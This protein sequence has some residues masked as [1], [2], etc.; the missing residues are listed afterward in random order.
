MRSPAAALRLAVLAA[1]AATFPVAE[2]HHSFA[3]EFDADQPVELH[4]VITKMEWLNPH[5]WMHLDVQNTDG[6]TTAWMIEGGTPNTLFRRGFT[7]QAVPVGTEIT[8]I[9]YRA[10]NG[11]NRANGRDLILSDGRR[12]FMG[13]PGTGAPGDE[14]AASE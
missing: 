5:T 6:T 14:G 13:S 1:F 9:G 7:P 10:R 3:A 8:V 12:L 4:G 11:A 2:A